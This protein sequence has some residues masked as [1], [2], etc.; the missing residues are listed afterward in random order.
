MTLG[1]AAGPH[2]WFN[3]VREPLTDDVASALE[4]MD[5]RPILPTQV[6]A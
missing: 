3:G 6:P 4:H 5:F 2:P 1:T